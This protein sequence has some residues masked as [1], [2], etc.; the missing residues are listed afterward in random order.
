MLILPEG[1]R[2]HAYF[3]ADKNMMPTDE[4]EYPSFFVA[5]S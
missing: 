3:G 5:S 4:V 1:R 2:Y